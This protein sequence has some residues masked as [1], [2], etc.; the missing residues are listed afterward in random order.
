[1]AHASSREISPDLASSQEDPEDITQRRLVSERCKELQQTG[2]LLAQ[3]TIKEGKGVERKQQ[4]NMAGQTK[5]KEKEDSPF[6]LPRRHHP[7]DDELD[8]SAIMRSLQITI[9]EDI[10][11]GYQGEE[12]Q[13]PEESS[14]FRLLMK[15]ASS[16]GTP[17]NIPL[18]ALNNAMSRAWGEKYWIIDQIKSAMYVAYF[19][20]DDAMDFVLKRQ[21]WSVDGDNLLLEWIN[22]REPDR[23]F[24]D[25]QF[26]YLYVP[27]RVYGVPERFR[28]PHLMKYVIDKV[29]QPSDLHPP[30]EITMTVRKDFV[31]A[32]AKMDI[33]KPVKDKVKYYVSPNEYILFY[34]N[35]DKVKRICIFCGVMFHSVQHCPNRRKLIMHLQSIQANTSSVPFANIGIWTSQAT[36]IPHTAFQQSNFV[37]GLSL[38]YRRDVNLDRSSDTDKCSLSRFKILEERA[39]QSKD[40]RRGEVK[41]VCSNIHTGSLLALDSPSHLCGLY[42][43]TSKDRQFVSQV[44]QHHSKTRANEIE[45]S[46]ASIAET[47]QPPQANVEVYNPST[48][49]DINKQ[50]TLNAS[51][52]QKRLKRQAETEAIPFEELRREHDR[53]RLKSTPPASTKYSDTAASPSIASEQHDVYHPPQ[54]HYRQDTGPRVVSQQADHSLEQENQF[55]YKFREGTS[56]SPSAARK[57]VRPNKRNHCNQRRVENREN[58]ALN[59]EHKGG[60][61]DNYIAGVEQQTQL[62]DANHLISNIHANTTSASISPQVQGFQNSEQCKLWL[63]Q[64][65]VSSYGPPSEGNQHRGL[66]PPNLVGQACLVVDDTNQLH[67]HDNGD[68][69]DNVETVNMDRTKENSQNDKQAAAPAFKAP[70]AQ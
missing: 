64:M 7:S 41:Y 66:L 69:L 19:R 26:R 42:N 57:K 10:E 45:P 25:Y 43:Q 58:V 22:P 12:I 34:L 48:H 17:R 33:Q 24:D 16:S 21:P 62:I 65:A 20:D 28:T 51:I 70:R 68:P 38:E 6:S 8:L 23:D 47:S 50:Q 44:P 54:L 61:P 37:G 11:I 59:L 18:Q 36:K 13:R 63:Q 39:G 5:H 3:V 67:I 35:Y 32:Y 55:P 27:I 53:T 2:E 31:Q 1:M 15:V 52:P 9:P 46:Q 40:D 4:G 29:A 14:P 56:Q 49:A 30:P 60:V